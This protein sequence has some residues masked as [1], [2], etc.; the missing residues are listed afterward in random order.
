[1]GKLLFLIF[2]STLVLFSCEKQQTGNAN[3]TAQIPTP[4]AKTKKETQTS[5]NTYYDWRNS[6]RFS[7][8]SA[9]SKNKIWVTTAEDGK[10]LFTEDGGSNWRV[11]GENHVFCVDFFDDNHGW[12]NYSEDTQILSTE[13]G[14]KI[15]SKKP[16]DALISSADKIKFTD[17]SNGWFMDS[18]SVL[19]STDGGNSWVEVLAYDKYLR[20]QPGDFFFLDSL[21]GWVCDDSSLG[22]NL[23]KTADAGANWSIKKVGKSDSAP[24][25]IFFV[26]PKEGWYSLVKQFFQTK[27]GGNNWN[28]ISSLPA[29]FEINSMYWLDANNGWLAGLFPTKPREPRSGKGAILRTVDGGKTWTIIAPDENAP[30][31]DKIHFTDSQNG[32]LLSRD[33]IYKTSDG[34]EKWNLSYSLPPVKIPPEF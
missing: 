33:N 2:Y 21:T 4:T 17:L 13:D 30:F 19:H 1:M 20:G 11:V 25:R 32:W 24:C 16:H 31:F 18:S 6:A 9:P 5:S 29:N 7:C 27:D 34:G 8:F 22:G 12:L 3:K 26:N 28:A 14:G 23:Y 15:W 10:L